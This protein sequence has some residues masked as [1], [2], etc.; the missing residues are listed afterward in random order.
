MSLHE[1]RTWAVIA[2]ILAVFIT[3]W[4]QHWSVERERKRRTDA[5]IKEYESW[6]C[7]PK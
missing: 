5:A 7:R 2:V 1:W 4:Y 6:M 3:D